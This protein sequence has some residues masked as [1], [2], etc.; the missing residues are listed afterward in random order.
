MPKS[1][2]VASHT[3]KHMQAE[4]DD[5]VVAADGACCA[6][7]SRKRLSARP[8]LVDAPAGDRSGALFESVRFRE[9]VAYAEERDVFG[10]K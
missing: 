4:S 9:V 10:D 7:P 8:A 1:A 5:L 3:A 6:R 2:L